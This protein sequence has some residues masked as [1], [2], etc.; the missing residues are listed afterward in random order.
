MRLTRQRSIYCIQVIYLMWG[1]AALSPVH[2]VHILS[3]Q[4]WGCECLLLDYVLNRFLENL[5][6]VGT[7]IRNSQL[8]ADFLSKFARIKYKHRN[9]HKCRGI[10]GLSPTD[11]FWHL[12]SS[13]GV[14]ASPQ[15]TLI[16]CSNHK[17]QPLSW[18]WQHSWAG[19]FHVSWE[20]NGRFY[21][22][23]IHP[24]NCAHF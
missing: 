8:L 24:W 18:L 13:L 21:I 23:Y 20:G 17:S 15:K 6:K 2:S 7:C 4:T 1:F 19:C 16:C 12:R 14:R 10:G 9:L 3:F 22:C 11:H 5:Y